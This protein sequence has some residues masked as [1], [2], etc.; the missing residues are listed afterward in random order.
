[1]T[2]LTTNQAFT[3]F[4]QLVEEAFT[5]ALPMEDWSAL[6]RRAYRRTSP[7]VTMTP[8]AGVD[9]YHRAVLGLAS[10][11]VV[12]ALQGAGIDAQC[13][14]VRLTHGDLGAGT[15]TVQGHRLWVRTAV[16]S[17]GVVTSPEELMDAWA[18]A[19]LHADRTANP[20]KYEP[21]TDDF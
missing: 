2:T 12:E 19:A 16:P 10:P 20:S 6:Y 14:R 13:T 4:R 7:G 15:V 3:S 5:D 21:D 8:P 18:R 11:R 17:S 1:M 9:A